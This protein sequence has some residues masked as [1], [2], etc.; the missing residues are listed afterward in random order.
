MLIKIGFQEIN[1]AVEIVKQSD[2]A[3]VVAGIEEGEFRDRAYLNLQVI[4][5]S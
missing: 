3:I 5:K 4:K 1:E 2:A